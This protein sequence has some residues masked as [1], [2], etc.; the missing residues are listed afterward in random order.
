MPDPERVP[1]EALDRYWD[2]L[3][4]GTVTAE[5]AATLDPTLAATVRRVRSLD[6][7]PAVDPAFVR[8]TMAHLLREHGRG[9]ARGPEVRTSPRAMA[10]TAPVRRRR[11]G[12]HETPSGRNQRTFWLAAILLLV[13]LAAGYAVVRRDGSSNRVTI[14]AAVVSPVPTPT[15]GIDLTLVDVAIPADALPAGIAGSAMDH[16]TIAPAVESTWTVPQLA[17]LR[18]VLEGT[19]SL[20]AD[21]PVRVLRGGAGGAWEEI[22]AGP[23]VE[24]GPGDSV[25]ILGGATIAF[26]NRG[27][28][29]VEVVGWIIDPGRGNTNPTPPEWVVHDYDVSSTG[30]IEL[31]GSAA[32][33]RL[34][35]I[36]VAPDEAVPESSGPLLQ[37][38]VLV[39]W[40]LAG[41]PVATP[42]LIDRSD[43]VQINRGSEEAVVYVVTLEAIGGGS[44]AATPA[45]PTPSYPANVPW[46]EHA[47]RTSRFGITTLS[48]R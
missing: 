14:P 8:R 3:F 28:G 2:E 42:L 15:P 11:P 47:Y 41:T 39:P 10:S 4:G 27:A 16:H 17:H 32:R 7:A 13:A 19:L 12:P 31:P 37:F 48:E 34:Q 24:L 44:V 1:A 46:K 45:S 21:L 22:P 26:A 40:N 29:P 36:I 33:L 43:G 18:H 25:L 23:D 35:R 6:R 5:T 38:A 30:D 20:R 9:A